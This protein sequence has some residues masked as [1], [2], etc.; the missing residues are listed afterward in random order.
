MLTLAQMIYENN[1]IIGD[2]HI[3]IPMLTS[4]WNIKFWV[5]IFYFWVLA[6]LSVS[7]CISEG[8]FDKRK[9]KLH[10]RDNLSS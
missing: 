6:R 3:G 10:L 2:F 4:A 9:I 1:V 7:V 5:F 8:F